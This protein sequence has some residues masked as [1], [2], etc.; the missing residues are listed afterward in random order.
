MVHWVKKYQHFSTHTMYHV[1]LRR[2]RR[3]GG[4]AHLRVPVVAFVLMRTM[5][6]AT[7]HTI[8]M[9]WWSSEQG[10]QPLWIAYM[11]GARVGRV[12]WPR[13][14]VQMCMTRI[15][16]Q[17][18]A[19]RG[20]RWRRL[21]RYLAFHWRQQVVLAFLVGLGRRAG[22][23]ARVAATHASALLLCVGE[24]AVLFGVGRRIGQWWRA[25]AVLPIRLEL[26]A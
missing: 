24:T 19:Q 10:R 23:A 7:P 26:S 3:G 25:A 2:P 5:R 13:H 15:P 1:P 4:R 8:I 6:H 17:R 18:V 14:H 11:D 16:R 12:T 9:R 22:R 20:K 21:H